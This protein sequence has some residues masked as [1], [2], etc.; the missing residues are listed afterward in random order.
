SRS[1]GDHPGVAHY[2]CPPQHSPPMAD[3]GLAAAMCYADI[4]PS[5]PHALHMPSH[6]FTRVGLWQESAT[7]NRRASAAATGEAERSDRLHALDYLV[8]AS[9]Q[10]ARDKDAATALDEARQVTGSGATALASVYARAAIPAR[11]TIERGL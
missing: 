6:I 7:T 10:L 5:A 4:A 2:L 11:Q 8:Y 3:K 9:L 1:L